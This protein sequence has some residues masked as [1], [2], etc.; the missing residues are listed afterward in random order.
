[1]VTQNG[2]Y[3]VFLSTAFGDNSGANVPELVGTPGRWGPSF[4]A[5]PT[6]PT[7]AR[8]AARGG[9]TWDPYV[10]RNGDGYL[11]Y[12]SAELNQPGRKTHCLGV[13][14][15]SSV[16]GPFVPLTGPPLVCQ[17]DHG[18]DIDVQ[19]FS[20]PT[21][22]DGPAHPWYLIW[23]SDDNNLR[24]TPRP[25]A[26]WAAPLADDGL[27]LNGPGRIIYRSQLSWQRPVIE[28]PQMTTS[29]DGR[30]W[31]FFSAGKGF[32]TN[33]YSMGVALCRGPLGGC[34]NWTPQPLV[35]TNSQG[36]G[37]GEE[38]VFVAPDRSYWLLYNPWHTGLGFLLYRPAEG[39][40]IGWAKTGP[41]V[42]EAGAF[43]S[44]HHHAGHPR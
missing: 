24:P 21:G 4:D 6:V 32:F 35:S 10:A 11:L 3:H 30:T 8:G 33:Q 29:P 25:T 17:R 38:T 19:P 15:S 2:R 39:V 1:M 44:P 16:N 14:R 34:Q 42:A 27:S 18:G 22:P 36:Q 12:F 13:A 40:R 43:P 28:A 7:W 26:I 37:P 5:M 41:Y 31:L 9:K 20:Y 23:K